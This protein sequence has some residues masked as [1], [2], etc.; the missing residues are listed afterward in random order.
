MNTPEQNNYIQY[1]NRFGVIKT[2][3]VVF[4][5]GNENTTFEVSGINESFFILAVFQNNIKVNGVGFDNLENN[6]MLAFINSNLFDLS[7]I[8]SNA[9]LNSEQVVTMSYN[10]AYIS[11]LSLN[12][13][14][15]FCNEYLYIKSYLDYY[16]DGIP[17]QL[18]PI[19]ILTNNIELDVYTIYY[20]KK[21]DNQILIGKVNHLYQNQSYYIENSKHCI[22]SSCKYADLQ[23]IGALTGYRAT[24]QIPVNEIPEIILG[25]E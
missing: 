14:L 5:K 10:N 11:S 13:S 7:T 15:S 18:E 23:Y 1:V 8:P 25:G 17:Y 21:A 12:N 16:F 4:S 3:S 19:N 2:K 22:F 20:L 9:F 6:D 24:F